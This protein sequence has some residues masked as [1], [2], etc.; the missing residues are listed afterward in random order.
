MT[1]QRPFVSYYDATNGDLKV[2]YCGDANC[3]Q[4]NFI[5]ILDR[6]G[7]V[8]RYTSM[9]KGGKGQLAISFYDATKRSLKLAVCASGSRFAKVPTLPC[10]ETESNVVMTIDAAGELP[11]PWSGRRPVQLPCPRCEGERGGVV[12]RLKE[13]HAEVGREVGGAGRNLRCCR[14]GSTRR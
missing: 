5:Q 10:Q 4:N 8:G 7:D 9:P 14:R 11:A 3:A 6:T 13:S 12:L 2:A 1:S